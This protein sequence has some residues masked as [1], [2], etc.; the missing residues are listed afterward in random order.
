MRILIP[1]GFRVND[2]MQDDLRKNLA[3][4]QRPVASDP[5][6]GGADC[7]R[8]GLRDEMPAGE[9]NPASP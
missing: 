3:S 6:S 1:G 5:R 9:N 8:D 2:H 4:Y 7:C